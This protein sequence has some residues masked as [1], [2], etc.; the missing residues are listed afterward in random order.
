MRGGNS[1]P[2]TRRASPEAPD[3]GLDALPAANA[4]APMFY[5]LVLKPGVDPAAARAGL[6]R[7]SGNRLNVQVEVNP[8][9]QLGVVR[10]SWR[11]RG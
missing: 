4:A 8:A 1:C 5:S 3:F 6:L 9:A 11:R 2:A 7:A 10:G